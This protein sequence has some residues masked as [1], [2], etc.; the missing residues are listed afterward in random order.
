MVE[1][2][3]NIDL[4]TSLLAAQR[5]IFVQSA[6][7]DWVD[8]LDFFL[9][10]FKHFLDDFKKQEAVE[11][12]DS[13]EDEKEVQQDLIRSVGAEDFN[14]DED[15]SEENEGE[16]ASA[17]QTDESVED[18]A[19]KFICPHCNQY[20]GR[21]K[22]NLNRHV[23][24]CQANTEKGKDVVFTYKR[25]SDGNNKNEFWEPEGKKDDNNKKKANS[26]ILIEESPTPVTEVKEE[27]KQM[28]RLKKEWLEKEMKNYV[29]PSP[30]KSI[31]KCNFCQ[32]SFDIKNDLTNHDLETHMVGEK[33]QC[34]IPGCGKLLSSKTNMGEHYL[35]HGGIESHICQVCQREC[36]SKI[37]LSHHIKTHD[38]SYKRPCEH[39]GQVLSNP[40]ALASHLASV[41]KIGEE[42]KCSYCEKVYLHKSQFNE[43]VKISH[44]DRG[45]FMCDQCDYTCAL[46]E[47]LKR[48]AITHTGDEAR[49]LTCEECG[50]KFKDKTI[51]KSH[52]ARVHQ[53]IRKYKCDTCSKAFHCAFKLEL[54]MK[55]HTGQKDF[56][57][58]FCEKYFIQKG[59]RDSHEKK[60]HCPPL[61]MLL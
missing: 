33:F 16:D 1:V 27:E 34:P 3:S 15:Q 22:Y 26:M 6:E 44:K 39:C 54:H 11:E 58:Q 13:Y 61:P 45:R 7:Q 52:I 42:F 5:F 47:R 53:N 59:N 48:H 51:L 55:I 32:V 23:D 29:P 35:L 10:S 41:H 2:E 46:K 14:A 40:Y 20:E 8:K 56:K 25:R 17:G 19:S 18:T 38:E 31:W 28:E 57:C 24:S 21:D 9:S 50:L 60:F 49:V 37:S 4:I 36:K 12:C 43:H 30:L